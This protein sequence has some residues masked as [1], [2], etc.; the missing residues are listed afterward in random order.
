[1][2]AGTFQVAG[3]AVCV[4]VSFF[5]SGFESGVFSLNRLRI[6]RLARE[7][8]RSARRLLKYLESPQD[9]LWTIVVGNTVANLLATVMILTWLRPLLEHRPV[10]FW[11]CFAGATL[12]LLYLLCELLPKTLF[13]RFPHRACLRLTLPFRAVHLVF[14]PVVG[15][16]RWIARTSLTVSGGGAFGGRWFGN[17]EE[18][19]GLMEESGAGL[20]ATEHGLINRVLDAQKLTVGELARPLGAAVTVEAT[21]PAEDVVRLCRDH[22]LTRLPVWTGQGLMRRIGGVVNLKNLLHDERPISALA[23]R[24]YLRPALYFDEGMKLE[25]A[26]GRM[27]RSGQHFAIVLGPD[28]REMGLITLW[29]MLRAVFV[30]AGGRVE[31]GRREA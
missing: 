13:Q 30:G 14:L 22:Q 1:M 23:A 19:R 15:V 16:V 9:F 31:Q 20:T 25:A 5:L 12:G 6:R 7:G 2:T 11:I 3:F 17:R 28:R 21:T 18:L 10:V 29:D 27:Q 4:V 8:N 26:L 24:D